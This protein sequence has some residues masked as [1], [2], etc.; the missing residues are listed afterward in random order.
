MVD[1]AV[2]DR[3]GG[4]RVEK[5]SESVETAIFARNRGQ[6]TLRALLQALVDALVDREG[7]RPDGME[8]LA[9]APPN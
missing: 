5:T 2:G 1:D 9:P 7:N 4:R 3:G 8:R 6:A